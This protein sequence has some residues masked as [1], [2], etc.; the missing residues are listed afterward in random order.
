M[1]AIMIKRMITH[2]RKKKITAGE[3]RKLR[4]LKKI[5]RN[6][7]GEDLE[8]KKF[9]KNEMFGMK[10]RKKTRQYIGQKLAVYDRWNSDGTILPLTVMNSNCTV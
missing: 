7:L 8:K 4:K 6:I 9:E 10:M 1:I 5:L 2:A 3:P